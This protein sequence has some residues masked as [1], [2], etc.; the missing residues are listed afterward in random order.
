MIRRFGKF[1]HPNVANYHREVG[2]LALNFKGT[3]WVLVRFG[4]SANSLPVHRNFGTFGTNTSGEVPWNPKAALRITT[5]SLSPP[6]NRPVPN[7]GSNYATLEI[8]AL[9]SRLL[10]EDEEW[11]ESARRRMIA[12]DAPHLETFFLTHR[13]ERPK[14]QDSATDKP[15][16]LFI[17]AYGPPGAYDPLAHPAGPQGTAS[18]IAHERA[19]AR[20]VPADLPRGATGATHA[21]AD[22]DLGDEGEE[23]VV[24]RAS[25]V[26]GA[27]RTAASSSTS[28]PAGSPSV[29]D[30]S[31]FGHV[32]AYRLGRR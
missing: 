15:P 28:S 20:A 11:I 32:F 16:I 8:R 27:N 3:P 13:F 14:D 26:C 29:S 18:V 31:P 10:I 23:L 17:S 21:G 24:V 1:H 22:I 30:K 5:V 7:R 4:L 19:V 25:C 2:R 12:G 6:L 9:A